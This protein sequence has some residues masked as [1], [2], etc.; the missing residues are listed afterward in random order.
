MVISA[1]NHLYHTASQEVSEED[2]DTGTGNLMDDMMKDMV[3][4]WGQE[5]LL[6]EGGYP[7]E[8]QLEW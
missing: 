3:K 2:P 7:E 8:S 5:I 4:K 1:V 6:S